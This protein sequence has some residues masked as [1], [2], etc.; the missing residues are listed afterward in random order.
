MPF[1]RSASHSVHEDRGLSA[2]SL[3]AHSSLARA[4]ETSSRLDLRRDPT[5]TVAALV[6]GTAGGESDAPPRVAKILKSDQEWRAI[7][8]PEEFKVIREG[9]TEAR[10]SSPL[11]REKRPGAL[12]QRPALF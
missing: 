1:S 3:R 4:H 2:V 9:G 10:G 11:L 12:A 5:L 8:S 6:A 7:L